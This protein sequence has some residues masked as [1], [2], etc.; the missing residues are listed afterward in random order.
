MMSHDLLVQ[1]AYSVQES[2]NKYNML[3]MVKLPR[4]DLHCKTSFIVTPFSLRL[5][6]KLLTYIQNSALLR[7]LE[8]KTRL[9]EEL[10]K[11]TT[12]LD[13]E[14]KQLHKQFTQ[15]REICER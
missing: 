14:A 12:Q 3:N 1:V 6:S 2:C 13:E 10:G 4:Q 9:T 7:Q 15:N 11:S 5:N 8:E